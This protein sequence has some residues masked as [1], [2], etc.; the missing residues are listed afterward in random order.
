MGKTE[1]EAEVSKLLLPEQ[2]YIAALWLHH[3]SWVVQ[4]GT[5]WLINLKYLLAGPLRKSLWTPDL[6]DKVNRKTRA[7]TPYKTGGHPNIYKWNK[8][9]ARHKAQNKRAV[10]Q[11]GITYPII[12]NVTEAWREHISK[13]VELSMP[14]LPIRLDIVLRYLFGVFKNLYYIS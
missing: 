10:R 5:T 12:C 2:S 9:E 11:E 1:S 4:T 14:Y 7:Y 3:Q 6:G 13:R 8:R